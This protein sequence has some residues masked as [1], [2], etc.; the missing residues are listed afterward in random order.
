MDK[1]NED[2]ILF[3]KAIP[4]FKDLGVE[5]QFICPLCNGKGYATKS[6]Y[7]GHL[8][9]FCAKCGFGIHQ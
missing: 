4:D 3:L 9:A 6:K 7:N 8:H 2:F 5:H 1:I